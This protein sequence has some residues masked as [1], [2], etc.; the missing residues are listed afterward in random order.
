MFLNSNDLYI[1][2]KQLAY[3]ILR[4]DHFLEYKNGISFEKRLFQRLLNIVQ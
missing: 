4:K 1:L 3:R 2:A